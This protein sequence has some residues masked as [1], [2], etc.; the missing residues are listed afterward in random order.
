MRGRSVSIQSPINWDSPLN[1]GL[2]RWWMCL[3]NQSRWNPFREL[4]RRSHM[5]ISGASAF[6]S[7]GRQG[8]FGCYQFNGTSDY[9]VTSTINL[10]SYSQ[11]TVSLWYYW[12]TNAN[13]NDLLL[14]SGV[15]AGVVGGMQVIPNLSSGSSYRI[16]IYVSGGLRQSFTMTR[17]SAGAW[18]HAVYC[19]DR[20]GGSNQVV[21][22]YIDGVSQT[23]T[24]SET[25]T[26]S[27]GGFGN[28]AWNF[29]ARN[30][31]ASLHGSGRLDDIRIYNRVLPAWE[32]RALMYASRR[33][34]PQELRWSRGAEF[35][36][37]AP[38]VGTT[39]NYYNR[40]RRNA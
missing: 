6:G 40:R 36:G 17:P 14:E 28:L 10:S 26:G 9:G 18:H 13:D 29:M 20:N 19:F 22:V 33:G 24:P 30:S 35:L 16:G 39:F 23:L 4:T 5:T 2:L 12:T 25:S 8:G 38:A 21:A 31:G 15:D 3:P 27:S 34:Y 32:A 7:R 11:L 37:E 1:R